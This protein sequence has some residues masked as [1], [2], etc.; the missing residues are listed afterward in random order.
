MSYYKGED[1]DILIKEGIHLI[2]F[3]ADWC[4]RRSSR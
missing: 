4:V 2:D 1:F 3:Y